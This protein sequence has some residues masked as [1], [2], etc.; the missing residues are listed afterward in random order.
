[1]EQPST[2][3]RELRKITFKGLRETLE[4]GKRGRCYL[5][6]FRE[7]KCLETRKAEELGEVRAI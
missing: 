1:M 7:G 2:R 4:G 5:Q 6:I 3:E